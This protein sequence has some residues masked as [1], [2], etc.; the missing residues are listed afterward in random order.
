[1]QESHVN[2][3]IKQLTKFCDFCRARF[4]ARGKFG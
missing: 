1:M 4:A 3:G 2:S